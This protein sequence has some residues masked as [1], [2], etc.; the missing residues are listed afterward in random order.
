M[1]TETAVLLSH[2]IRGILLVETAFS[3]R[4]ANLAMAITWVVNRPTHHFRVST[5]SSEAYQ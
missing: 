4:S 1:S 3:G 5:M 2:L